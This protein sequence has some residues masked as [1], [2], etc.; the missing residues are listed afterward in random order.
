[1]ATKA[2]GKAYRKG[3]SL[4]KLFKMF[5][6]DETARKWYEEQVWP[7]GPYCPKCGTFN[8]QSGIKHKSM[9]HRCRECPGKPRFS[10]RTGTVLQSSKL[11]YRTW[12]IAIYLFATGIKGTSSMK[13]HRDLEITYKSAWHLAH[14]LRKALQTETPKF[15]GPVEV[16]EAFFGGVEGNKHAS[17]RTHPG[18]GTGGKVA[19]V[20]IRDQETGQVHAEVTKS[21]GSEALQGFVH[22]NTT[23]GT[24]VYT[25]DHKA[26]R[27]MP[28]VKHQTVK[29]SVGEYVNE[30]ATTNGV[31]SFWALMKRGYH[32]VYHHWSAKHMERYIDEFEG[33]Y[34]TRPLDTIDQMRLIAMGMAGKRLK[35]NEL[36]A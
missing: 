21:I 23:K 29:H 15:E 32:G 27:G 35:Y 18:G 1:M 36:V 10:L 26:Y 13:L 20:G 12:V 25:D 16:D 28:D 11:D 5:P 17:K 6:D 22:R 31:E 7:K 34:N 14:R 19:V 2:P 24:T 4:V 30:Q 8:V 3:L 9:T 33:R